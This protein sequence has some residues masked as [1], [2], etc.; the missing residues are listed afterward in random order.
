MLAVLSQ[1]ARTGIEIHGSGPDLE[2][3]LSEYFATASWDKKSNHW[4]VPKSLS[5]VRILREGGIDIDSSLVNW[6]MEQ[7]AVILEEINVP[8]IDESLPLYP[9][10]KAGV[11]KLSRKR[12]ALLLDDLGLGKTAQA[13]AIFLTARDICHD[14]DKL[15]VVCPKTVI[16]SWVTDCFEKWNLDFKVCNLRKKDVNRTKSEDLY[17]YDVLI[18][19]YESLDKWNPRLEKV[20]KNFRFMTVLDEIVAAKSPNAIRAKAAE[21][22]AYRSVR[23]YGLTGTLLPNSPKDCWHPAKIVVPGIFGTWGDFLQQHY[24]REW[25]NKQFFKERIKPESLKRLKDTISLISLRRT[26]KEVLPDLPDETF[27]HL[28]NNMTGR[29]LKM[30]EQAEEEF[31]LEIMGAL[32]TTEDVIDLSH[33]L[34]RMLRMIQLSS[35]PAMLEP[36]YQDTP[37]KVQ[38]LDDVVEEI[39]NEMGCKLVVWASFRYEMEYLA[40][41]YSKLGTVKLYGATTDKDRDMAIDRFIHDD[42]IKIFVSNPAAGGIG[43]NLQEATNYAVFFDRTFNALHWVQGRGRLLR[44]GQEK[45]VSNIILQC[46]SMDNYIQD[47]LSDKEGMMEYIQ[48]DIKHFTRKDLII[49]NFFRKERNEV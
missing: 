21:T 48:G 1:N 20:M 26:K 34:T 2:P 49:K 35:H 3:F 33:A 40:E 44:I 36:A 14:T 29:Q 13:T 10:Q 39:V 31:C 46:S 30:Y 9:F 25:V 28:F 43:I 11:E 4:R 38:M 42:S 8:R 6:E 16:K 27:N 32:Q 18:V 19:N 41:R 37:V 47:I 22:A 17:P 7:W 15:L 12:G 24:D 23:R 5:N 45:E